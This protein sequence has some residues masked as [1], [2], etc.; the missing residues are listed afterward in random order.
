M[1]FVWQLMCKAFKF[2]NDIF[3]KKKLHL[4]PSQIQILFFRFQKALFVRGKCKQADTKQ[5]KKV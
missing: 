3:F 4:K 5:E 2:Q 1:R